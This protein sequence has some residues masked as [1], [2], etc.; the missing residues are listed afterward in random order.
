MASKT[1]YKCDRCGLTSEEKDRFVAVYV[2]EPFNPAR[3]LK[4]DKSADL[5]QELCAKDLSRYLQTSPDEVRHS[6][7]DRIAAAA[8]TRALEI[9]AERE[10]EAAKLERPEW[11]PAPEGELTEQIETPAESPP[12]SDEPTAS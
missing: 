12:F 9:V 10:A 7:E 3:T 2:T 5:C 4:G 6:L 11:E 8:E 1:I